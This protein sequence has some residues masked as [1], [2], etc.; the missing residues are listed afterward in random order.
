MTRPAARTAGT[1]GRLQESPARGEVATDAHVQGGWKE[2]PVELET[3]GR[4]IGR[5][6]P[7]LMI[8]YFSAIPDRTSAGMAALTMPSALSFS[9]AVFGCGACLFFFGYLLAEVCEQTCS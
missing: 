7:V 8:R 2:E 4:V 5:L 9:N 3:M 1:K 6:L